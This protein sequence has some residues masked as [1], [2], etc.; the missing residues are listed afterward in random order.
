M[1]STKDDIRQLTEQLRRS[2][3]A[4]ENAVETI[5]KYENR[6]ISIGAV[7]AVLVAASSFF[8]WPW[9]KRRM[10]GSLERKVEHL[11]ENE[12]KGYV[13]KKLVEVDK[14]IEFGVRVL[15]E[16]HA[17]RHTK[18]FDEALRVAGWNGQRESL[19]SIEPTLRRPILECLNNSK[20]NRDHNRE[21]AWEIAV[22]DATQ[23]PDEEIIATVLKIALSQRRYREGFRVYQGFL[24]K[25]VAITA[26]HERLI[27]VL[28]RKNGMITG[29]A[30]L[31]RRAIEILE[32]HE[33]NER[34]STGYCYWVANIAACY[35][36]LGRFDK[37]NELLAPAAEKL[38]KK[39]PN[40]LPQDWERVLNTYV[41]NC[42]DHRHID[43][44]EDAIKLLLPSQHEDARD[45]ANAIFTC[46]RWALEYHKQYRRPPAG[47][48]NIDTALQQLPQSD[49]KTKALALYLGL[50][51]DW[52]NAV[53]TIEDEI[54]RLT[55][56][57][58]TS[59]GPDVYYLKCMLGRCLIEAEEFDRAIEPLVSAAE[60]KEGDG[61]A[62]FEYARAQVLKQNESEAF[63]WLMKAAKKLPK[64]AQR[65]LH[66]E[67][68]KKL[69]RID[70]I[71]KILRDDDKSM[72]TQQPTL[73]R[74]SSAVVDAKL[75]RPEA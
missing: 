67:Q 5:G 61:E 35:R 54:N 75:S 14:K 1:E 6:A 70:E 39:E 26:D 73:Q 40:Q 28:F 38:I 34:E 72:I 3:G 56:G 18:K 45:D 49:A 29:E 68:L 48:D 50:K 63:A 60:D 66:D 32:R 47:F 53:Q 57:E 33:P 23:E 8:G 65:A 17:L 36:D 2:Q 74:D 4:Y 71:V 59:F 31:I 15:S 52:Q 16:V 21:L 55:N 41:S 30:S 11:V 69:E 27:A 22:E 25:G 20:T 13:Q 10:V 42:I 44:A 43:E 9:L 24:E 62:M 7:L 58:T 64:W 46:L 12:T 19:K 37:A 51:G